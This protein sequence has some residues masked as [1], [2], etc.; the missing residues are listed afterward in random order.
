VMPMPFWGEAGATLGLR[1][2]G[3]IER[4]GPMC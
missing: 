2:E 4:A 3:L 1:R